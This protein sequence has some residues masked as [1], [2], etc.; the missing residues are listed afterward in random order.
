MSMCEFIWAVLCEFLRMCLCI[1]FGWQKGMEHPRKAEIERS[2]C[3]Q[4][5]TLFHFQNEQVDATVNTT[6]KYYICPNPVS[7]AQ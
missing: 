1:R 5:V 6:L 2:P 3:N 7:T 4:P